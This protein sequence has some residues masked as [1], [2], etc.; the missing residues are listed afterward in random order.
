MRVR[1]FELRLI[2]VA[3]VACWTLTAALVLLAYRPGGPID[4]VVGVL[5]CVPVAIAL[6]AV[7]W[8]P[9]T[10]GDRSFPAMVWLGIGALLVLVPSMAGLLVQLRALGSQTLLPSPEA[11]YPW[12]IALAATSLF[13]G[14]GI[15][16][17]LLGQT[18]MRRRR[19]V[20]GLLIA[21]ALTAVTSVL[22]GGAALAN[23][24]AMRDRTP[25]A[26]RFGPTDPDAEPSLCTAP[27]AVGPAAKVSL[28]MRGEIDLRPIGSVDL[29][30]LRSGDDYRWLAYVATDRELATRGRA[31]VD[32]T[33]WEYGPDGGWS[34]TEDADAARFAVDRSVLDTVLTEG[35]RLTAEDRGIEVIEGARARRCRVAVDGETF[36]EAFPQVRW[37][38]GDADL[39][40]WRGQL[41]YWVFLDGQLG[42]V[43]GSVN[44]DSAGIEPDTLLG[45][46]ELLLTATDRTEDIVIYP[47]RS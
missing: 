27:L 25:V 19:L 47:P 40:R 14:F 26:S 7:I 10:H 6:A 16:R 9:V 31:Y 21:T 3:L 4:V 43:A 22:L 5:A 32:G 1:T 45:T 20:R 42:Q 11:A 17:A 24:I 18:A 36:V 33:D 23:D 12:L 30:G 8:P 38:V 13:A 44:G 35:F 46:V 28:T 15:A 29:S 39:H 41:D 37:L 34:R 2:G